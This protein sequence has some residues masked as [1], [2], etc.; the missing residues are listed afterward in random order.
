MTSFIGRGREVAELRGLVST[1]RLVT[2]LGP[3]GIGKTRLSLEAAA[4]L[5]ERF[6]DGIYLVDLAPVTDPRVVPDVIN[7]TLAVRP[8]VG[9]SSMDALA[10]HL[11][12]RELLLLLDNL[13]QIVAGAR[14][15]GELLARAPR[16]HVLATSRV[17]LR[18]GGETRFRLQPMT[19]P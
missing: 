4:G 15:V 2:A 5:R 16:L 13:E 14:V 3:G 10:T 8:D 6:P 12:G 18:L 11:E 9:E 19:T 7:E 1:G 17:P